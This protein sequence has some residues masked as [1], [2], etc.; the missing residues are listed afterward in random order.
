MQLRTVP[1]REG[2]SWV[3]L[4]FVWLL[5]QPWSVLLM[6]GTYMAVSYFAALGVLSSLRALAALVPLL[7][8]LAWQVATVGFMTAA[9]SIEHG[10]PVW[11]SV[12]LTG[13]R[14]DTSRRRAL[15]VLGTL[16]ALAVLAALS[17]SA[18]VDGGALLQMWIL[19]VDPSKDVLKSGALGGAALL[20]MV[21][22]VPVGMAFWFA[23]PLVS[24]HGMGPMQA[25]FTSFI[26]VLRNLRAFVLYLL[27]WFLLFT[28]APLLVALLAQAMHASQE[29]ALL[30]SMPVTLFI[31]LAYVMSFYASARSLLPH[32]DAAAT[33]P[34]APSAPTS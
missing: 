8:L 32:D 9:R 12:L 5:R 30:L 20:F 25:L 18:L 11:P 29:A 33:P 22:Y 21:C 23:P 10:Q 2:L 14:Q 24:W 34:E 17:A 31:F 26:I 15:L 19:G 1:A 6:M 3:K 7:A 13:L 28:T 4:G 27:Q 16:Y